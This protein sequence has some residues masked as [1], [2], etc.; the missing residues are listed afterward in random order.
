MTMIELQNCLSQA[1]TNV[2][3]TQ[4][5][6]EEHSKALANAEAV[7]RIA[8]QMINNSDVILRADKLSGRNDRIDRIVG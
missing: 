3:D 7:A 2:M 6:P 8:K 5:L 4:T 1:L